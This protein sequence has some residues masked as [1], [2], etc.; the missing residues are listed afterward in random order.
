MG[1]GVNAATLPSQVSCSP[2]VPR[3]MFPHLHERVRPGA[4][5]VPT[6]FARPRVHGDPY[7][8]G[9]NASSSAHSLQHFILIKHKN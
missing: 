3:Q 4:S 9:P 7:L 8:R 1:G 2:S 5:M 6:S